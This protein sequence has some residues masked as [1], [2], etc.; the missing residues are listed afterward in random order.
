MC[1]YAAYHLR[2]R[3]QVVR[4]QLND[5]ADLIFESVH[6]VD[7]EGQRL[8]RRASSYLSSKDVAAPPVGLSVFWII[9]VEIAIGKASTS[10]AAV[11]RAV[12]PLTRSSHLAD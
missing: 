8:C 4:D 7:Y 11:T 1:A 6:A 3:L 5:V 2:Q 9:L 12:A 10:S